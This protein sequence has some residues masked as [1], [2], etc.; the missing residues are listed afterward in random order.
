MDEEALLKI[1]DRLLKGFLQ[2]NVSLEFF[3][4]EEDDD[5]FSLSKI[6]E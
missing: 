2:N 1:L 5:S 4:I 6:L 3:L